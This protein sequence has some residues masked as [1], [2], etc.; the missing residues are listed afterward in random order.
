MDSKAGK[1]CGCRFCGIIDGARLMDGDSSTTS[2]TIVVKSRR[3]VAAN[4]KFDIFFD[5]IVDAAGHEVLDYLIVDPKVHSGDRLGGVCVLPIVDGKVALVQIYRHSLGRMSWEAP[6]GFIDANE[7]SE[8]AALRELTEETGLACRIEMLKPLGFVTP[9]PGVINARIA[10]FA[11]LS[12]TGQAQVGIGDLG[13]A[14]V[15]IADFDDVAR[16]IAAGKVEDATTLVA[17]YRYLVG[18]AAAC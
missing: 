1:S 10:L 18:R 5:N 15:R 2:A 12:C 16:S 9:E 6:K 14:K 13:L 11:A 7:S 8:Q 4:A 17:Y 3:H